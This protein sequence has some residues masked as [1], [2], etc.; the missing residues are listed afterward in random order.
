MS[1]KI[2][3]E[4]ANYLSE[5]LKQKKKKPESDKEEKS[6]S[7]DMQSSAEEADEMHIVKKKGKKK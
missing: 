4:A 7:C 6:E 2:A 3:N 5:K 1:L